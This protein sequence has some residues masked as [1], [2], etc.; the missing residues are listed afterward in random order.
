MKNEKVEIQLTRYE[1]VPITL[2]ERKKD[3]EQSIAF[4]NEDRQKMIK[5]HA[6]QLLEANTR[7]QNKEVELDLVKRKLK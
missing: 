2:E 3:L 7:I 1:H 4:W 5:R 6:K